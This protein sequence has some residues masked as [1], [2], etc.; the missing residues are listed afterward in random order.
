MRFTAILALAFIHKS[1]GARTT[2]AASSCPRLV[3]VPMLSCSPR[4]T[5]TLA[6]VSGR[7][8]RGRASQGTHF[9][10]P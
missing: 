2:V 3:L 8:P 1:D 9:G 7:E 6:A 5:R 10:I 4:A